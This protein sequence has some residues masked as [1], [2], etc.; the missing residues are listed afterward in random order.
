MGLTATSFSQETAMLGLEFTFQFR[1]AVKA[2]EKIML[3]WEVV[4]TSPKA[5]L[6][7]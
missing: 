2:G 3:E 7:G 5:S 4:E 6:Q 1:K